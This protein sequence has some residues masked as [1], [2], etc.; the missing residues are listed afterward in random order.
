M[1]KEKILNLLK[2]IENELKKEKIKL[3]PKNFKIN[4]DGWIK[5]TD[6]N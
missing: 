6:K 2:E 5:K 3:E 1:N 4:S